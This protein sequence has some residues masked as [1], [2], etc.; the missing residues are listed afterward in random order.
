VKLVGGTA[1]PMPEC[2][3]LTF[4]VRRTFWGIYH[5]T[6]QRTYAKGHYS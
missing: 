1:V 2:D 5:G 4:S 6:V 3:I